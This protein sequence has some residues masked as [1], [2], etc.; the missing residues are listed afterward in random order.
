MKQLK[1]K[2][3]GHIIRSNDGRWTRHVTLWIPEYWKRRKGQKYAKWQHDIIKT[4]DNKWYRKM[5]NRD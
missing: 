3:A 4:A 2:W 5:Y 1:W